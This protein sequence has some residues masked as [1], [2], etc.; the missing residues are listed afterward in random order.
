[1]LIFIEY[2]KIHTLPLK[3]HI[4][5]I[6]LKYQI[7]LKDA[8]QKNDKCNVKQDTLLLEGVGGENAL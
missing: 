8:F 6:E 2:K 3:G 7:L 5:I 1:V 4:F